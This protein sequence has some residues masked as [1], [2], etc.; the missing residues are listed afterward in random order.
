MECSF[1]WISKAE[2]FLWAMYIYCMQSMYK[3][4][5]GRVSVHLLEYFFHFLFTCGTRETPRRHEGDTRET[6]RTHQHLHFTDVLRSAC[7]SFHI[8]SSPT[9]AAATSQIRGG[10]IAFKLQRKKMEVVLFFSCLNLQRVLQIAD[11]FCG[12]N[13]V[14]VLI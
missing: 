10:C 14:V 11:Y 7:C 4:S 5:S 9:I 6:S 12:Q 13:T 3:E 8:Q 1:M 2:L